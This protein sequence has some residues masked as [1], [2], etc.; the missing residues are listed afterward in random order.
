MVVTATNS[1]TLSL[2]SGTGTFSCTTNPLAASGGMATFAGCKV[3]HTG[4]TKTYTPQRR[5]L[6][7]RVHTSNSFTT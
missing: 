7:P 3:T 1:I 2:A 6:R 5:G 4:G